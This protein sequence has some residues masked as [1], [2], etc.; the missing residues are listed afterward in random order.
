MRYPISHQVVVYIVWDKIN[1]F[2]SGEWEV[3]S[4]ELGR[5]FRFNAA[6]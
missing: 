3:L 6:D 4:K 5:E 2:T 1:A